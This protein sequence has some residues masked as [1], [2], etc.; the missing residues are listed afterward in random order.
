MVARPKY[1]SLPTRGPEAPAFGC[2][3]DK[4]GSGGSRPQTSEPTYQGAAASASK[5]Y[6]GRDLDSMEDIPK[7]LTLSPGGP[8]RQ[9]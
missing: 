1:V 7:H 3:Q 6:V 8:E 4:T 9:L 2:M 5:V